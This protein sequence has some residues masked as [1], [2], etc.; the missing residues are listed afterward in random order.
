MTL[1]WSDAAAIAAHAPTITHVYAPLTYAWAP[2]EAY[3][4]RYGSGRKRVLFVGMNPGPFGMVQTGIPFGDVPSVRDWLGIVAPVDAPPNQDPKKPVLGFACPRREVSGQRLWGLFAERFGTPQRF[5]ADHFVLNYCPLAFLAN[6]RNVT[7]D[8]LPAAVREPLLT[9]CDA[10][11][12]AVV[13]LLQP[14]WVVGI[15]QW[16]AKRA[17]QALVRTEGGE[18]AALPTGSGEQPDPLAQAMPMPKVVTMLHP[19]PASSAA[20]RGWAAQAI[21]QLEAAGIW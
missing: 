18:T 4:S 11:L 12:R 13:S 20:N 21:A 2:H 7:P 9:Q 8:R 19:S 17:A 1:P 3:L 14:E 5:F 15:G 10:Y 6:G 16:A